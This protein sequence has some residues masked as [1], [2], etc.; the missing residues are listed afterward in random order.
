[1]RLSESYKKRIKLL[2]GLPL[3]E[4]KMIA[5]SGRSE[6]DT[7]GFYIEEYLLNLGGVFLTELDSK[8]KK[9]ENKTLRLYQEK[10]KIAQNSLMMYFEV[11]D[12]VNPNDVKKIDFLLNMMVKLESNSNTSATLEYSTLNDEFNLQSKHSAQDVKD[13]ISEI[14]SRILNVAKIVD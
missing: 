3:N 6:K 2:S 13:F 12:N 8:I 4:V 1:M 9:D 5:T 10:T 14:I 11:V 7:I